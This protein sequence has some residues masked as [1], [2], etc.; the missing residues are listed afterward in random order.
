[1]NTHDPHRIRALSL[2]IYLTE[3]H[4]IPL[5]LLDIAD[6][7]KQSPVT[8]R[9]EIHRFFDQHLQ[10]RFSLFPARKRRR[11]SAVSGPFQ[12]FRQQFMDWRIWHFPPHFLQQGKKVPELSAQPLILSVFRV[13]RACLIDFLILSDAFDIRQ[14][15][16]AASDHRRAKHCGKGDLLHR[17]VADLEI[18][19]NRHNLPRGKISGSGSTVSRNS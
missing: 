8:G 19:Q 14:F 11:I 3:I 2:N 16:C 12:D 9:L 18:I 17:I 5:K 1:M 10:V 7:V 15:L 6:K 4:L 13:L